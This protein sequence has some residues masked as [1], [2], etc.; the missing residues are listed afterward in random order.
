MTGMVNYFSEIAGG[1]LNEA[2]ESLA[3]IDGGA[4]FA[5]AV[6]EGDVDKARRMM[7]AGID[8]AKACKDFNLMAWAVAF[9]ERG[10]ISMLLEHGADARTRIGASGFVIHAAACRIGGDEP[11]AWWIEELLKGGAD[12]EAVDKNLR[13]PLHQASANFCLTSART[14]LREGANPNSEA[15]GGITPLMAAAEAG[16]VKIAEELLLAGSDVFKLSEEGWS[17]LHFA[18]HG[19]SVEVID[20]LASRGLSQMANLKDR[21]GRDPFELCLTSGL[22]SYPAIS[23]LRAMGAKPSKINRQALAELTAKGDLAML[24]EAYAGGADFE[25]VGGDGR[26]M[27]WVAALTGRR[28]VLELVLGF[29]SSPT[30]EDLKALRKSSMNALK[31]LKPLVE[32]AYLRNELN[33][34][35]LMAGSKRKI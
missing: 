17:A 32:A 10:T 25:E 34:K 20:F 14:L 4:E 35:N 18:A 1:N 11:S 9:G 7:A 12:I 29:V 21:L 2:G 22:G 28:Y 15:E 27:V 8:V 16:S 13:T 6:R 31:D 26:S 33:P 24:R 3:K 5:K 19:G 30:R 23:A